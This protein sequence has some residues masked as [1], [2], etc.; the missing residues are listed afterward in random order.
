MIDEIADY[1]RQDTSNDGE[2]EAGEDSHDGS[3]EESTGDEESDHQND[4]DDEENVSS[5]S[6]PQLSLHNL[7]YFPYEEVNIVE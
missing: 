3:D 1:T 4:S 6:L 2:H 7:V 5:Y